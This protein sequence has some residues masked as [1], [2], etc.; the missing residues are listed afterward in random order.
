M[1]GD[2]SRYAALRR[3]FQNIEYRLL[4]RLKRTSTGCWE[5]TGAKNKAGYG[6]MAVRGKL[7]MT[8]R[9]SFGL[10]CSQISPGI[11]VC[12]RCDNPTCCNPVHLFEG[13]AKSNMGDMHTKGR[14]RNPKGSE[15]H[16]AKITEED[17]V[18]IRQLWN[19]GEKR[20]VIAAM[21]NLDSSCVTRIARGVTWRHVPGWC[22]SRA[23]K[24]K[25]GAE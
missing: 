10:F 15:T 19:A 22:E 12:H 2:N 16:N 24:P 23:P 13:D 11:F 18:R 21:Y 8:H 4:K 5:W 20:E 3:R 7:E 17:V 1:Y 25:N 6:K 9:I 14:N